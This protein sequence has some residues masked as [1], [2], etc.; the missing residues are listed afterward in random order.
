MKN[1][2]TSLFTTAIFSLLLS[3]ITFAG[4][5]S[6][7]AN[8]QQGVIIAPCMYALLNGETEPQAYNVVMTQEGNSLT[9]SITSVELARQGECDDYSAPIAQAGSLGL[10][11]DAIIPIGCEDINNSIAEEMEAAISDLDFSEEDEFTSSLINSILSEVTGKSLEQG[12][13]ICDE[14]N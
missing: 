10:D 4:Q 7:L 2:F 8:L 14:M 6:N 5:N 13:Y 3:G 11:T 12:S 9:F 1:K